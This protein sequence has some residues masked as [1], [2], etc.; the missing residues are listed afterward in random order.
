MQRFNTWNVEYSPDFWSE[1]FKPKKLLNVTAHANSVLSQTVDSRII[2]R[3][4]I[5]DIENHTLGTAYIWVPLELDEPIY[6]EEEIYPWIYK[7]D[8]NWLYIDA[9][10]DKHSNPDINLQ[11]GIDFEYEYLS[12]ELKCSKKI[13]NKEGYRPK[14]YISK[15]WYSEYR[16]YNEIGHL[17]N[18]MDKDSPEYRDSIAPILASLYLGPSYIHLLAILNVMIGLPIAKYDDEEVISIISGIVTTNKSV[19]AIGGVHTNLKKGDKL[20]RFQ[21]LTDAVELNTQEVKPKWWLGHPS[22]AFQ[23]YMPGHFITNEVKDYIMEH[24]L[25]NS[26]ANV[27]FAQDKLGSYQIK[28]NNEIRDL[29]IKLSPLRSDYLF[30]QCYNVGVSYDL[31][32]NIIAPTEEPYFKYRLNAL[33][34]YGRFPY[35]LGDDAQFGVSSLNIP[36]PKINNVYEKGKSLIF[37][38]GVWHFLEDGDSFNEFWRYYDNK[39]LFDYT[40]L[41]EPFHD[42]VYLR[43][44]DIPSFKEGEYVRVPEYLA[45]EYQPTVFIDDHTPEEIGFG[46]NK[47]FIQQLI[48]D[49][50]YVTGVNVGAPTGFFSDISQSGSL[51]EQDCSS[52]LIPSNSLFSPI[53]FEKDSW[54]K[55]N[56]LF[57]ATGVTV[58]DGEKGFIISREIP[59]GLF[60]KNV[61]A[62]FT[63]SDLVGAAA[64]NMYY[65][66]DKEIW[67]FVNNFEQ[68]KNI[69]GSIYFKLILFNDT[70]VLNGNPILK[71]LRVDITT[72]NK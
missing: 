3:Y 39:N 30:A 44:S 61:T 14:L 8:K 7:I 46:T 49:Q 20:Y 18:Y 66:T 65:S 52:M 35:D 38:T 29:F 19:Y 51:T 34:M 15:G 28:I 36:R 59:V 16:I 57:I 70:R 24:Y 21:P 13:L 63:N 12:G 43:I 26:V 10:Y 50:R 58:K 25:S 6:R 67:K 9:I 48:N 55:D 11:N 45:P 47:T 31:E 4:D 22:E 53:E 72:N 32:E 69:S 42:E 68:I 60:P 1:H 23:K 41:V 62:S 33:S 64:I 5:N 56:L 27:A 17:L 71:S 2:E 40:V 54:I 37:N